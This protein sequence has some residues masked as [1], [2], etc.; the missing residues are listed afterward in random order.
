MHPEKGPQKYAQSLE[1]KNKVNKKKVSI[2]QA[3]EGVVNPSILP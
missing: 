1:D 3:L 2:Q